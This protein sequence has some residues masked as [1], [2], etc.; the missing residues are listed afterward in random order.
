M[1]EGDDQHRAIRLIAI[2]PTLR[3][4]LARVRPILEAKMAPLSEVDLMRR[5]VE[6]APAFGIPNRSPEQWAALFGSYLEALV[7][8]SGEMIDDA[9]VRWNRGELYPKE[10]GRHAFYPRPAELFKLAEKHRLELSMARWR[11]LR[12]AEYVDKI[13]PRVPTQ[14]ERAARRQQ[15]IDDG[16]LNEDGSVNFTPRPMLTEKRSTRETPH[17]MAER[18]RQTP[19][20]PDD[21]WPEE[22]V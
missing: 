7:P 8:L 6:N 19:P 4:E 11:A 20:A 10:P 14:E 17:E 12:A 5:L 2:N 22:A 21:D 3:A 16:L 13:P 1:T 15:L 9:F 18:L